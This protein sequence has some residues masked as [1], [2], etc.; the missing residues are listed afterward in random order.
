M[1]TKITITNNLLSIRKQR[2]L[3]QKQVAEKLGMKC[4]DRIS[5]WE[6]GYNMPSLKNLLRL[7]AIYRVTVEELYPKTISEAVP[8]GP[9]EITI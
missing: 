7:C 9:V 5:H 8:D 1:Q 3:I 6:K 4:E 2:G